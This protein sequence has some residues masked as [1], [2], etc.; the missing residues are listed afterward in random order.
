MSPR[1]AKI[2]IVEDDAVLARMY[3]TK[4]QHDGYEVLQAFGGNDGIQKAQTGR[5]DLILLDIMMPKMDGFEVIKTLKTIEITKDIPVI[6]LTNLGMSKVLVDEAR[7]LG[8][9][10]YLVK[11]KTSAQEVIE[12]VEKALA[13]KR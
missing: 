13:K 12:T 8:V 6:I 10:T 7:R 2:L 5:P 9:E 3:M 1:K 11:Y 4:F